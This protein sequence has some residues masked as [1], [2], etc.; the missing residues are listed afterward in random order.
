MKVI[1][2]GTR[3][4]GT[5][6][7]LEA[8]IRISRFDITEVVSGHASSGGDKL[9]ED[10]AKSHSIK[11]TLFPAK[12]KIRKLI[13]GVFQQIVDK[14][15]GFKRNIEMAHYADALIALWDGKSNGT[16]HMIQYAK[17][18]GLKVFVHL[19]KATEVPTPDNDKS[20]Y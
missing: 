15:A 1:I 14:Q 8:A 5:I 6:Q 7:D 10:Y 11:L 4:L 9:G 13:A 18:R 3:R 19:I 17:Q 20:E 16:K 12:W 2:A